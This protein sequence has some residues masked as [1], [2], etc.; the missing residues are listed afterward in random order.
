MWRREWLE[1]RATWRSVI[2]GALVPLALGLPVLA[3]RLPVL[4]QAACLCLLAVLA[5][6]LASGRRMWLLRQGGILSRLEAAPVSPYRLLT[7][8][9]LIRASVD[10]VLLLPLFTALLARQPAG[11]DAALHLFF[12]LYCAVWLAELAGFLAGSLAAAAG[13]VVLYVLVAVLPALLVAGAFTPEAPFPGLGPAP[14]AVLPFTRLV[15]NVRALLSR[16]PP[17]SWPGALLEPIVAG[18]WLLL[19]IYVLWRRLMRAAQP[20]GARRAAKP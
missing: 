19:A 8:Y 6:A 15:L 2:L 10:F 14:L 12:S 16:V 3:L 17:V 4:H 7:G 5:P 9:A 1:I 13:E 18:L 20:G 11:V